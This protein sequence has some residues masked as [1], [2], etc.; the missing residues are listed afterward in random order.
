MHEAPCCIHEPYKNFVY[1]KMKKVYV[2]K[3]ELL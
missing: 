1:D 3:Q 2:N